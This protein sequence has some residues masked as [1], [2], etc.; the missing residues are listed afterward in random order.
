MPT[1]PDFISMAQD[2]ATGVVKTGPWL[3]SPPPPT[4]VPATAPPRQTEELPTP[5]PAT[6]TQAATNTPFPTRGPGGYIRPTDCTPDEF[7]YNNT[8]PFQKEIFVAFGDQGKGVQ[9][10]FCPKGDVDLSYFQVKQGRSYRVETRNL[11]NGVDTVMAVGDLS[12]STP[13]YPA[14]CWNDDAAALTFASK[15]EFTAVEDDTALITVSNRGGKNGTEATYEL[16]V[17]EI[18]PTP[19][20]SPSA[21][22]SGTTTATPTPTRTPRP[23]A[24][25]CEQLV[26]GTLGNQ[27]CSRACR[28]FPILGVDYFG[29][30]RVADDEDW[31]IPITLSPGKY[32]V[33]LLAPENTEYTLVLREAVT[34]TQNNCPPLSGYSPIDSADGNWG[35]LNF[36]VPPVATQLVLQVRSLYGD[37]IDPYNPYILRLERTGDVPPPPT[38]PSAT[39]TDTPMPTATPTPRFGL[40]RASDTPTAA[41]APVPG[42][43]P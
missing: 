3:L 24:D 7:E 17:A 41:F 34:P 5:A 26:S 13:C 43:Q 30:I 42:G 38:Q 1:G 2:P 33:S 35:W 27:D 21:Y 37:S 31:F 39:A 16:L 20:P 28:G 10:N 29:S 25:R 15:I 11:A 8:R 36:E 22:P 12:N 40:P 32:R 6:A 4:A 23:F 18:V 9:H 19:T 14:G